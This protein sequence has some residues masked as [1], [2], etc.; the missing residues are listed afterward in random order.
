M[1]KETKETLRDERDGS[2]NADDSDFPY[3]SYV[4]LVS[5]VPIKF[6]TLCHTCN[7]PP[8]PCY[9][10]TLLHCY[11]CYISTANTRAEKCR[12]EAIYLDHFQTL[13]NIQKP[14]TTARCDD[15][16][17]AISAYS[18]S[19]YYSLILSNIPQSL[20]LQTVAVNGISISSD[21]CDATILCPHPITD[22]ILNI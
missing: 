19:Y 7:T 3:V 2:D 21:I 13:Y 6:I 22:H 11:T 20:L 18:M 5:Y 1:I 9:T 10:V 15:S 14:T 8:T 17:P 16:N 4:P 12:K